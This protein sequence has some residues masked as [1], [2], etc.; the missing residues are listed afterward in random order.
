[1]SQTG[2]KLVAIC[3][4]LSP[5]QP[6][7]KQLE[8]KDAYALMRA[9]YDDLRHDPLDTDSDVDKGH[10]GWSPQWPSKG[11]CKIAAF[12]VRNFPNLNPFPV[13]ASKSQF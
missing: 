8:K 12:E 2:W 9:N 11:T 1:M 6:S 4:K 3:W 10:C 13:R 7:L 5:M